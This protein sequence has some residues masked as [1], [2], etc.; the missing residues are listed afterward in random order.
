MAAGVRLPKCTAFCERCEI[1]DGSVHCVDVH[2]ANWFQSCTRHRPRLGGVR[3]VDGDG[4]RLALPHYVLYGAVS[5]W[6]VGETCAFDRMTA[7]KCA[8]AY[9]LWADREQLVNGL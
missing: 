2:L 7:D 5:A 6:Q 1:H 3:R 9:G 8:S 4:H